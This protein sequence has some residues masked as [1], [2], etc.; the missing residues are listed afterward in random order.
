[1]GRQHVYATLTGILE[2]GRQH[3]YATL[4]DILE[5]G[6]QHLYATLTDILEMGRQHI[7]ATLT[8]TVEMGRQHIHAN[9]KVFFIRNINKCY[10]SLTTVTEKLLI[11]SL[12]SPEIVLFSKRPD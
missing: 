6:R 10:G 8:S 9:L 1:M 7:Y 4:T 5:M 12:Q 3:L 2:M 11:C